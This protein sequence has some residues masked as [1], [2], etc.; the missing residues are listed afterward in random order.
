MSQQCSF[1][2]TGNSTSSSHHTLL[3]YI[4]VY[5]NQLQQVAQSLIPGILQGDSAHTLVHG[6][7]EAPLPAKS[8]PELHALLVCMGPKL[9]I[10][11]RAMHSLP[12]TDA[13]TASADETVSDETAA[14]VTANGESQESAV[15][16]SDVNAD[17]VIAAATQQIEEGSSSDS[18]S[19]VISVCGALELKGIRGYDS[20]RYLMEVC[21]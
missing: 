9:L 15:S 12:P 18:E 6:S 11:E 3:R 10:A 4:L 13:T 7:V 1:T 2:V 21:P 20:R 16:G 17:A 5:C 19:T 14:A 8:D